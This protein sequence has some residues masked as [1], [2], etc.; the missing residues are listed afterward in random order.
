VRVVVALLAGLALAAV[1]AAAKAPP[2]QETCLTK[3]E[4]TRILRYRATDGVRLVALELGRG[5]RGVVLA[6]GYH[7]D[8]CEWVGTERRLARAGYHVAALDHRNHGSSGR[9]R[10]NAYY[11]L[12]RD[13]SATVGLLRRRGART[14]V[15]MGS[16]MGASSVLAGAAITKPAVDGVVSLSSPATFVTLDLEASVRDVTSPTLFVASQFDRDFAADAQKLYDASAAR[17]KRLSIV[18]NSAAHG[19]GL[20]AYRAIRRGVDAFLA[21]KSR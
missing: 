7:S 9:A 21:A 12:D 15:L 6:H 16:S 14:V 2:L 13:I 17:D 3:A 10:G 18:R 4:K 20:L 1:P 19:A 5:P 8:L 11:R